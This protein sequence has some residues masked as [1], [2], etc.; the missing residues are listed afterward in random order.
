MKRIH[1]MS[2]VDFDLYVSS[3]YRTKAN[4]AKNRGLD[5]S[6]T[7]AEFRRMYTRTRCEY[8]GIEMNLPA[9]EDGKQKSTNLTIERVDNRLGYVSGNCIAVCYAANNIKSV[10]ENPSAPLTLEDAIRMFAKIEQL[11]KPK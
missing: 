2:V 11:N 8:T 3:K 4:D 9:L 5:F 1:G 10:F 6:M 7:F